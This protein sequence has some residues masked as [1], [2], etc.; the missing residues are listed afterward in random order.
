[1]VELKK[2][3]IKGKKLKKTRDF[4]IAVNS[5]SKKAKKILL[6]VF[7]KTHGNMTDWI[8]SLIHLVVCI[9]MNKK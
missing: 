8:Y 6:L 1:M 9:V 5:N 2:L 4:L 3:K 7:W